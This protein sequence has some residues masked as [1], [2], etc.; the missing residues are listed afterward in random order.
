MNRTYLRAQVLTYPDGTWFETD[1][2]CTQIFCTWLAIA[3]QPTP[4]AGR[5]IWRRKQ[6]LEHLETA[7]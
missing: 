6:L 2:Q 1:R 4:R 7:L 3:P 5:L